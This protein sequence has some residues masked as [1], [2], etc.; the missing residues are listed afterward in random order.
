MNKQLKAIAEKEAQRLAGEIIKEVFKLILLKIKS[1]KAD[2]NVI[3]R[4]GKNP[5]PLKKAKKK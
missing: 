2:K 1:H 5:K 4:V 3:V